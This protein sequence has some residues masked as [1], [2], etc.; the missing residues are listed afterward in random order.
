MGALIRFAA[1]EVWP[2]PH[3]VLISTTVTVGS[4]FAVA[5]FLVARGATTPL[6]SFVLGVC[7]SA[8]SLSAYAVLTVSQPPLLSIAFLTV[9]PAAAIAG[10]ICGL[11][12][13][14]AMTR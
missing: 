14:K 11:S 9:I 4:A 1:A 7:A 5:T 6:P 3:Q 12:A 10:L 13:M 8:A 2:Q